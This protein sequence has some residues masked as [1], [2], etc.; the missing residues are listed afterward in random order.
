MKP[1]IAFVTYAKKPDLTPDDRLAVD[2]LQRVGAQTDA[3]CWDDP[4]A[5][6]KRY[7]AVVVRSC[8][9]YHLR[10][11]EFAAWLEAREQDGTPLWNPAAV[12]RWNMDK[13]YLAGLAGRG[14]LL[15]PTIWL[16][17]GSRAEL[18][19]I[20]EE[21]GWTEA[22]VKPSISA[23]A[24]QTRIARLPAAQADQRALDEILK[25]SGAL[26]QEFLPQVS[27]HGEWSLIFFGKQ[28]SHAA[29]KRAGEGE[30]R[31]QSEYGGS[32]HAGTPS[33][34][35]IEQARAVLDSV[36][37]ELLYARVDGVEVD[38]RLV[39]MELELIEPVLF[40]G[41]DNQ[42]PQRFAKTLLELKS[43]GRGNAI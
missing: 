7:A 4:R 26:V 42:A 16:E 23:S 32:E 31:V 9:D 18:G 8:W 10:P 38:G 19:A 35:L 34:A 30:F 17:R 5:D 2:A 33:P 43:N 29:L 25:S 6:W 40:F 14:A 39:L 27:Q 37:G 3:L 11:A 36:P 24:Y 13:A 15:P 41:K 21:N 22:V 28:F 20:L 1:Q 12:L